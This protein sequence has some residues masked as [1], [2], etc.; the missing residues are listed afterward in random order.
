[1]LRDSPDEPLARFLLR[2]VRRHIPRKKPEEIMH[3]SSFFSYMQHVKAVSFDL[4]DRLNINAAHRAEEEETAPLTSLS[5]T[6]GNSQEEDA[7]AD[8]PVV[9]GR[10][11]LDVPSPVD[12]RWDDR[13]GGPAMQLADNLNGS[14]PVIGGVPNI[15]F[16]MWSPPPKV[17][18]GLH[19]RHG[20]ER[21]ATRPQGAKR[22]RVLST[23]ECSF[24]L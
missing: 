1:M 14:R 4:I 12:E 6:V 7:V 21:L 23:D 8:G 18:P 13:W 20:Q 16:A 11:V 19:R 9:D 5:E 24:F 17:F 2:S 22:C 15:V 3:M 10:Y